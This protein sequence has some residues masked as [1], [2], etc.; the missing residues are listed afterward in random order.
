M[1]FWRSVGQDRGVRQQLQEERL[2]VELYKLL[3]GGEAEESAKREG[4]ATE[5]GVVDLV[6]SLVVGHDALEEELA[7]MLI[8][9]LNRLSEKRDME[10]VHKVFAPLIKLERTL[11]ITLGPARSAAETGQHGLL[12][13]LASLHEAAGVNGSDSSSFLATGLL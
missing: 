7:G 12:S 13:G 11:P 6:K 10:F 1:A 9:D 5:S 4:L 8:E 3:R 2:P